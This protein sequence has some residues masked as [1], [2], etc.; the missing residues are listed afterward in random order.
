[1]ETPNLSDIIFRP[2]FPPLITP[3]EIVQQKNKQPKSTKPTKFPNSFIIYRNEISKKLKSQK[4]KLTR[5]KVS[6]LAS[7]LWKTEPA[8]VKN[9]Y[10]E[11]SREAVL[12]YNIQKI[13]SNTSSSYSSLSSSSYSSSLSS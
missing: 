13:A 4:I 6:N 2:P 3:E 12:L 7:R 5:D 9:V 8:Y 11:I 10:K 1:M